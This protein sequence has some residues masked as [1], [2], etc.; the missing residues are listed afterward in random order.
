MGSSSSVKQME[1]SKENLS[2][3][4]RKER[5]WYEETEGSGQERQEAQLTCSLSPPFSQIPR[6]S[7]CGQV[8]PTRRVFLMGAG[9]SLCCSPA[10]VCTYSGSFCVNLP[11]MFLKGFLLGNCISSLWQCCGWNPGALHMLDKDSTTELIPGPA[12]GVFLQ[13]PS[14]PKMSPSLSL[15]AINLTHNSARLISHL[16]LHILPSTVTST[17]RSLPSLGAFVQVFPSATNAS[18]HLNTLLL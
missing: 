10:P 12:L 11:A 7:S 17:N 15:K 16:P 5:A 18:V 13:L 2:L 14:A 6:H 1:L 8:Q 4:G 9:L 3:A